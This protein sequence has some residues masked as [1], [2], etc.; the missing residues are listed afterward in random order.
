MFIAARYRFDGPRGFSPVGHTRAFRSRAGIDEEQM[1]VGLLRASGVVRAGRCLHPGGRHSRAAARSR[2]NDR[3]IGH[4]TRAGVNSSAGPFTR[5]HH[6]AVRASR[7]S[8][9]D[10]L[11]SSFG[12]ASLSPPR[13]FGGLSETS[14]HSRAFRFGAGSFDG[15][16]NTRCSRRAAQCIGV[17]RRVVQAPLAAERDGVS[18]TT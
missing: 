10:G 15:P 14:W 7:S 4:H 13:R 5:S 12:P 16:S 17:D 6:V 11:S 2:R 1:H 9:P 3:G 8:R 18:R